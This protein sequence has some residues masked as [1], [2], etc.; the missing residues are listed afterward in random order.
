M[1]NGKTELFWGSWWDQPVVL[2]ESKIYLF[3]THDCQDHS[4]N[5]DL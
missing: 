2:N 3:R 1:G 5:V 4:H